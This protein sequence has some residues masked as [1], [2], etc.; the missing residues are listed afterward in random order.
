MLP[1][2]HPEAHDD[3]ATVGRPLDDPE[4]RYAVN[5]Y[6]PDPAAVC[7]H[8]VNVYAAEVKRQILVEVLCAVKGTQPEY[9]TDDE[10]RRMSALGDSVVYPA[11]VRKDTT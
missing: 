3:H 5:E 6:T 2:M 4:P 9:M 10:M 8:R 7:Y 1:V 11:L